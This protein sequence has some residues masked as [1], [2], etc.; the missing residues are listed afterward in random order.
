MPYI[1]STLT[2][3]QS[4]TDWARPQAAN[5]SKTTGPGV[6]KRSVLIKGTIGATAIPGFHIPGSAVTRIN[7]EEL[8][9]LQQHDT[10]IEM[11]NRGHFKII[12]DNAEPT[13]KALEKAISDMPK[14]NGEV[15]G[16]LGEKVDGS[17]QL[18]VVDGDFE[19]GGRAAGPAPGEHKII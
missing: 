19:E 8:E 16:E 7:D 3:S 4:I 9:F 12:E 2:N 5:G 14:D 15:G 18:S 1:V 10:F 13:P 11:F 6:K 17:S